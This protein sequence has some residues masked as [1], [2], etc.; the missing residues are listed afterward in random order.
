MHRRHAGGWAQVEAYVVPMQWRSFV[1]SR[2]LG[3]RPGDD[4]GSVEILIES[5]SGESVMALNLLVSGACFSYCLC[6]RLT[7]STDT[8][9]YPQSHSLFAYSPDG[10]LPAKIQR[11]IDDLPDT[12]PKTLGQVVLDILKMSSSALANKR[13]YIEISDDEDGHSQ[14]SAA[15]GYDAYDFE[16]EVIPQVE[17]ASI[18]SKLQQ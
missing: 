8:S 12:A 7:S 15:D 11:I 16:E 9:E 17:T 13:V 10:D 5:A 6:R 3:V 18:M 4:D 1:A 14:S 2:C